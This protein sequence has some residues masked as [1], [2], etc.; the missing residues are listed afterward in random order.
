M[1]IWLILGI[2]LT[3][4]IVLIIVRKIRI[5]GNSSGK[6]TFKKLLEACCG[7]K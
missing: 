5:G 1:K 4:I 3:I 2:V 7:H 6:S